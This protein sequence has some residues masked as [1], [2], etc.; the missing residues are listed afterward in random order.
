MKDVYDVICPACKSTSAIRVNRVGFFQRNV[1]SQFGYFP[2]KCGACGTPF[3]WRRRGIRRS[4]P[5]E[6]T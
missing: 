3:L 4:K 2:W 6:E 1:L 5:D